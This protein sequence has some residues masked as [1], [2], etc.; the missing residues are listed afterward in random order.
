MN[1]TVNIGAATAPIANRGARDQAA[2]RAETA[3]ASGWFDLLAAPRLAYPTLAILGAVIFIIN[4]GGYPLYTKG[5]PREAVTVFD[6]V[7]G[8]GIVLPMRAGVEVPSKP[9]LMHWL[10][11]TASILMGRVDEWSVRLP[12]ALLAI[13]GILACYGYLRR[14]FNDRAGLIAALILGTSVQYLQAGSGARVD[15]TLT[16]FMEIA[17]FEFI[18]IAEGMRRRP[19]LMYFAIA[20]AVLSK[21]PVGLVLPAAVAAAWIVM[22]RRWALIRE[23]DLGRGAII[24]AVLAG[25]WYVAASVIGG[26]AFIDKQLLAENIV[27]FFGARQFHEGHAHPF[28]YLELALMAGMLPWTPLFAIAAVRAVRMPRQTDSRLKYLLVWLV[29]V[30][31]FYS[32]AHSKRG[33]YLLGLYPALAGIV[34]IYLEDAIHEPPGVL[35][36]LLSRGYGAAFAL[37]GVGA[38]AG[39]AMLWLWPSALAAIF[40]WFGISDPDFITTLRAGASGYLV[41]SIAI[42]IATA[43][44]GMYLLRSVGGVRALTVA[45]AVAMALIAVAANLVVVPAIANALSLKNFAADVVRAIDGHEAAYL[46]ALDYD[47]AFYSRRNI[48]IIAMRASGKPEYL[49]SWEKVAHEMPPADRAQYETVLTSNPTAL[50]NTGRMVLLRRKST[51]P[52]PPPPSNEFGV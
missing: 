50:D 29:V 40:G 28:Y 33:V 31:A 11:A 15:T 37:A 41:L 9:L 4:L 19:Y 30:L 51:Q 1:E 52:A 2:V 23:L 20:M 10:A 18:M 21:G 49:I 8:G 39:L 13:A 44:V 6:I 45:V 26:R 27:R 5:E 24:V 35:P 38:L 34:A 32:F 3:P 7:S 25:W 16:F 47:V 42:P 36:R 43:A 12:S 17:F 14:L 48:P 22:E 46:T